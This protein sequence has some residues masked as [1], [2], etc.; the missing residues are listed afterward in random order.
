[1]KVYMK[2]LFGVLKM[3]NHSNRVQLLQGNYGWSLAIV[4][5]FGLYSRSESELNLYD[6]V[7]V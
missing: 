6:C 5:E 2:I 7:I 1:M 3:L 4:G